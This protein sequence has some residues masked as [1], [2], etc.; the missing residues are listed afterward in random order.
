MAAAARAGVCPVRGPLRPMAE[1]ARGGGSLHKDASV[2][3]SRRAG[4][5]P[6]PRGGGRGVPVRPAAGTLRG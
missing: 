4:A 5:V 2:P 3:G 1:P 6:D